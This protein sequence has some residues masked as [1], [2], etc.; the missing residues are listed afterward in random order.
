MEESPRASKRRKLDT[1]SPAASSPAAKPST[2]RKSSRLA[3]KPTPHPKTQEEDEDTGKDG[4][5]IAV[6]TPRKA[7]RNTARS[8]VQPKEVRPDVWDDIEAASGEGSIA[9]AVPKSVPA[10][11]RKTPAKRPTRGSDKVSATTETDEIQDPKPNSR[12]ARKTNTTAKNRQKKTTSASTVKGSTKGAVADADTSDELGQDHSSRKPTTASARKTASSRKSKNATQTQSTTTPSK[13]ALPKKSVRNAPRAASSSGEDELSKIAPPRSSRR[14]Q[15]RFQENATI[16]ET[17]DET[18]PVPPPAASTSKASARRRS[19]RADHIS[20]EDEEVLVDVETDR[21]L[22]SRNIDGDGM[23]VD[24]NS[25]VG[26]VLDPTEP[27]PF[28]KPS[29]AQ[30]LNL[31]TP[32]LNIHVSAGREL[33]LLKT[34]VLERISGK[35]P[36]P[37]VNLDEEYASV[38]QL[39][40]Q[41]VT[42]G[43]G[44]SLLVIGARGS[45]KTSLVNKALREV[46][47]E[48]GEDYHVVRLN[49]FIHTDDK[50]ALREIWR[51]LGK[52]MDLDEDEGGVGKN[53]A[54]TLTTLLALLSHP[55]EQT[56]EITDHIAKAVI[57]VMDEFDL[58]AQHARQTL[59]YNLFDI[60]QSRKAPIA[61]LGLTTRIDVA[62]SLEKRVKSRFSHRYVHLSLAKTFSAFQD[63]CKANLL[64]Y[65]DQLSIPERAVL[66]PNVNSPAKKPKKG[67]KPSLLTDW[68]NN[69]TTLFATKAFLTTH[70]APIY[71]LTK[72]I[73]ELLTTFLHP[74]STLSLSNTTL[75]P[76]TTLSLP[77]T[78]RLPLIPHLSTLALSLLIA[79]ARL[80]IIHDSDTCNFNMAYDEYVSLASKARIQN[81]VGGVSVGGSMS[82]VWGKELARREWEGLAELGFVVPVLLGA[83]GGGF[84]MC[85]ID[86][87]LEEIGEVLR[88]PAAKGVEKGLERWCR[89][90]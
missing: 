54:D 21:E 16:P 24:G 47:K 12:A 87:A 15:P 72:S 33:D 14:K 59:L 9:S 27:S 82:K 83:V 30:K 18:E 81:G 51:Q 73:P 49:G 85:R 1:T 31:T 74:L 3:N 55:S 56:G 25:I 67:S 13:A 77:P 7:V 34:I 63:M 17:E 62:N 48:N 69:I 58:F 36:A 71:H 39:V 70:L 41:T 10:S 35:R 75:Q 52:E 44:N 5:S 53:Y 22:E 57:F 88:G 8:I 90:I 38:H 40:H 28:N 84:G 66:E 11:K 43:E 29:P 61:V 89:Q 68:N 42:A 19:N 4:E 60:A 45:G 2:A 32:S 26:S 37:L 76:P 23:S 46:H 50:I 20:N 80:D 6:A 64:V 65:A 79:A 78:S 86:V